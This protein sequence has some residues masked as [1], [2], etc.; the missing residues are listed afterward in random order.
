MPPR[1]EEPPAPYPPTRPFEAPTQNLRIGPPQGTRGQE[2]PTVAH[3]LP[4]SRTEQL[5]LP[6]PVPQQAG[7]RPPPTPPPATSAQPPAP[8]EGPA[9]RR[10]KRRKP[11]VIALIGVL[12]LAV[13]VGGLV[14]AEL[15]ARN[16]AQAKLAGAVACEAKDQATVTFGAMPPV[17][18]QV[19]SNRFTNISVQTAGNQLGSAKGVKADITVQGVDLNSTPHILGA[20]DATFTWSTEGIKETLAQKITEFSVKTVKTHPDDGT[21]EVKGTLITV[22]MKP[23]MTNDK[24]SVQVV[25]VN[26]GKGFLTF[27]LGKEKE[28]AQAKVDEMTNKLSDDAPLGGRVDSVQVTDSGLTAHFSTHNATL[29]ASGSNPCFA[30]L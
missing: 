14:G 1:R 12:L 20:L 26:V 8:S 15:Y 2:A 4:E 16:Q 7:Y 28:K 17:L 6:R 22:I 29:P 21:I 19:I 10:T 27:P 11:L 3:R 25:S 24:L 13:A 5:N 30:N 23:Q 9:P 18:W